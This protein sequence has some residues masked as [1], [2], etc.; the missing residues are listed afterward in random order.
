MHVYLS[1]IYESSLEYY[2]YAFIYIYLFTDYIHIN[3]AVFFFP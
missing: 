2:F 1:F 3:K